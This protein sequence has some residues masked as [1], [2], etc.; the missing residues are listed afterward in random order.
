MLGAIGVYFLGVWLLNSPFDPAHK[1][2]PRIYF[3]SDW[4]WY[5]EGK[6]KPRP[7]RWGGLLVALLLIQ[8]YARGW[9]KDRLALRMGLWGALGGMVGFP[10]GQ[11]IQAFH[12]WNPE[13][14][15]RGVWTH[16]G[17]NMNWWNWMETTYGAI[18][19]A[20][21]GLGLWFNRE[22]IQP[23]AEQDAPFPLPLEIILV[24]VHLTLLI[25]LEFTRLK[26]SLVYDYCLVMGLIPVV[27]IAGGRWWPYFMIFPVTL[28]P[29]IGKTVRQ[30]V[31]RETLIGPVAG[32][33][34]YAI[35]PLVVALITMGVLRNRADSGMDGQSWASRAL[36]VCAWMYFLLNLAVFHYAWPWRAWTARTPNNIAFM[37][38]VL[39]LTVLAAWKGR[40]SQEYTA[41]NQE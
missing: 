9:R 22:K 13:L 17:K 3:S 33:G 37:I 24:A 41:R 16:L 30:L 26:F 19:G 14:F 1:V 7:E 2:V 23:P 32:W 35:L 6:I 34:V 15:T 21:L 29:Y 5:P 40:R 28:V 25:C 8:A 27:A 20:S 10:C 36:L 31:Y 38:C 39:G 4:H 11:C 18:M 12:A